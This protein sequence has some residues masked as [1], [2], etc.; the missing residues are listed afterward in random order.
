[1][2]TSHLTSTNAKKYLSGIYQMKRLRA[3]IFN[4]A[5]ILNFLNEVLFDV[6]DQEEMGSPK[7]K[8]NNQPLKRQK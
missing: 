5:A 6:N 1:M 4:R 8:S 7:S 2:E 3:T